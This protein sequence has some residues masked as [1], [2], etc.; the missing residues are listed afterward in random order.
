MTSRRITDDLD[1]LRSVLPSHITDKLA[2]INQ[3]DDLLE[4]ILDIGRVP[5]ARYVKEEIT[6]S[7]KEVTWDDLDAVVDRV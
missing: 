7:D 1:A 4:V 6:L 2:Q 3:P 5:T